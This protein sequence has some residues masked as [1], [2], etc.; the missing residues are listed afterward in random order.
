MN[1][2]CLFAH[3]ELDQEPLIWAESNAY[4]LDSESFNNNLI[5]LSSQAMSAVLGNSDWVSLSL[6]AA[7]KNQKQFAARMSR[8]I[9]LIL[10]H[11]S[12][13]DKV[14]DL[15]R[16]AYYIESLSSQFMESSWEHFLAMEKKGS[17]L[18]ELAKTD[19]WKEIEEAKNSRLE[20]YQSGKKI[21]VGVNK[22]PFVDDLKGG[23]LKEV[24]DS[25][26]DHIKKEA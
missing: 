4:Y 2:K 24:H 5:R 20:A 3:Y 7:G 8:N 17:L 25:L 14:D 18:Q 15:V 9:Q 10:K 19:F 23:R 21:M 12:H 26:S 6:Q 16:G 1:L 13:L 11:E 22:Y